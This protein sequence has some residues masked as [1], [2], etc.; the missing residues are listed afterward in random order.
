VDVRRVVDKI[1]GKIHQK[2]VESENPVI[3]RHPFPRLQTL[4]KSLKPLRDHFNSNRDKI[5]FLALLSPM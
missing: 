4:G 2:S 1:A 3:S 5:Q